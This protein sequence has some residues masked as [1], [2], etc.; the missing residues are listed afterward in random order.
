MVIHPFINIPRREK[1]LALFF[2]LV[3]I[4]FTGCHNEERTWSTYKADAASSSYSV[5]KE[6]NKQNVH[7]L[8]LS[9][10]FNPDD[11]AEGS[12]FAASQC[13]PIIIDG[14]MYVA[15]ARHRI[16]AVNAG[17]G[18]L[19]WSFDPFN[20]GP[21]GGSFRG[22]TYWEDG[23]DK[24]IL[25]TGG[26]NL[27]ALNAR[28][29]KLVSEFGLNGKVSMNVGMR[30][31]PEKISIK[32]TSPGIVYKDFLIIGNEVSEL[33][34]AQPGY[35]RAYNVRTGK[36]EWTFHTV[37]K[38]GEIG[39]ETWPKD[40]WK[41][42]GGANCWG[43]FSLDEKR[44]WVF[45]GTGSPSYDFYGYDRI[46]K[47]LFG[48]C[49]VAL[50]AK[51]GKY[52]WHFQT[53]HHDL[54]DYDLPAPPNLVT[55]E[56]DGKKIDAVAQISK[57]GFLYVLNRETGE[58]LFPIEERPVPVSDVPGEE[59]WPTQPF[60]LKPKPYCRQLMTVRDLSDFSVA[61]LDSLVKMFNGLRH[62]GLFTPPSLK[63][64]LNLP[65]TIGGSEWGG[66]A[67]DP[68]TNIIYLKSNESPEIDLLQKIDLAG[69]PA[70]LSVHDNGKKIYTSFC[71]SCHKSDRKGDEP[72][73]PSLIDL[74]KRMS[75]AEALKKIKEGSGRMPSFAGIL[76]G[77]EVGIIDYLFEKTDERSLQKEANL[78]EIRNNRL[79]NT[80]VKGETAIFDTAT[81]YLNITAYAQLKDPE[82]R[83]AIKPPW[84]TLNAINLNTGEYEWI[85]PVGNI[86]ELQ[87]KGESITGSTGSPGPIVTRGGLVFLGGSRDKKF[88]AFDKDTGKLLWE[89]TLPGFAS[90]TP[91]TYKSNGKQYVAISVA[92]NKESPA[93]YVM[94]FALPD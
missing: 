92:G 37:P 68:S 46:G 26:D 47:N 59:T 54:W 89:T 20:G 69:T 9:W 39:Y 58:P 27:F 22:V 90:S 73:Y 17:N 8:K 76:K 52:I 49:V 44:G 11:A 1:Y 93:G 51:T 16:Y 12:R 6:I 13:N 29:G 40:A 65:G 36:L 55:I 87:K 82:D 33:Y 70:N 5:L 24:R 83:P 78:S 88:Q 28:T 80:D 41:Y 2:L 50:D 72:I 15:S 91:C 25:F 84:G 38:P 71:S 79:S 32:P 74:K 7:E 94:A 62:E 23:N 53:I 18:K 64:T 75:E 81:T 60:P 43:G 30:D 14:V 85:I 21:G 86:P 42:A 61:S 67:Y 31:D 57:V 63:G 45:L 34:G 56:R 77:N 10:T 3:F 66:A 35:I 48:N 4:I 19:I